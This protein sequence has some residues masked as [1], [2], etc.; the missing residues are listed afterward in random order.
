MF[1][2]TIVFIVSIGINPIEA[3]GLEKIDICHKDNEEGIFKH[4]KISAGS[5]QAHFD[6]HGDKEYTEGANCND[7]S[8]PWRFAIAFINVDDIPGYDNTVDIMVA[9]LYDTNGNYIVDAGDTVVTHSFPLQFAPCGDSVTQCLDVRAFKVNTQVITE[10][11]EVNSTTIRV[12]WK[13]MRYS[14]FDSVGGEAYEERDQLAFF[15][16][17][18]TITRFEDEITL[19]AGEGD[20]LFVGDRSP[21]RPTEEASITRGGN[22]M[23][24]NFIDVKVHLPPQ[25]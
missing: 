17:D 24:D 1:T 4:I 3:K 6:N 5:Q 10:V 15:D 23:D 22:G 25:P 7:P 18:G 19:G 13:S 9:G 12:E 20:K 11:G 2:A 16:E 14:W 8:P 21:S